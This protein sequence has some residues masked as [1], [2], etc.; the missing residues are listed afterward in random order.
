MRGEESEKIWGRE[1]REGGGGERRKVQFFL[2]RMRGKC[3]FPCA[4]RLGGPHAKIELFLLAGLLS[5]PHTKIDFCVRVTT[6]LRS[7]HF[8]M[9][10]NLRIAWK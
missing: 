3:Y 5:D 8:S 7:P 4:V 6:R 1:R 9:R 10:S 2:N